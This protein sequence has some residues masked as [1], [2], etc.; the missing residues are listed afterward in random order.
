MS[1]LRDS[2][3]RKI[4][5]LRI[6]VTDRCNLRCSYCMPEEGVEPKPHED[7]LTYEEIE[8]FAKAAVKAGISKIRLTGGEPLVRKD[9]IKLVDMLTH[10]PGLNDVSLTTNGIL[11]PKYGKALQEAGLKRINISI[12][13]L[14]PEVYRTLTRCG[15]VERA[16][17]GMKTALEFGL[18]PVKVNAVL[19]RGINDDPKDFIKLIYDYPV[20]V[21]F[22][23]FM[24]VGDW[25]SDRYISIDEL[26]AKIA[27]Y[28]PV[29]PVSGPKG[30]GP[31]TYVTFEGALGTLGFISA[32]SNHFCS[33]C[34]RLRITP[35]GKLRVCLFSD[36][37]FDIRA[38]MCEV[39]S[40]DELVAFIQEVTRNKPE[41]HNAGTDKLARLMSQI[42]G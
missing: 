16:L 41:R 14:N 19:I 28:G 1:E 22:I 23:E 31:A 27:K 18:T 40:G 4:D 29:A 21:R 38:K 42:G 30:A 10:I 39:E 37:E 17:E 8:R 2:Y 26:K 24:P 32:M 7:I 5:Y 20:H 36:T 6:A 33:S 34:N 3:N 13:S 11:L 9:I 35:D 25:D 12:D 15:S